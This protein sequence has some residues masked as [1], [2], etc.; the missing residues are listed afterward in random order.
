MISKKI[1]QELKNIDPTVHEYYLAK[2]VVER[3][4]RN[5]EKSNDILN[6]K[7]YV[8]MPGNFYSVGTFGGWNEY[9]F[10]L[11]IE[12]IEPYSHIPGSH[13]VN[14]GIESVYEKKQKSMTRLHVGIE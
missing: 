11:K 3:F 10:M 1:Q 13:Y 6:K 9:G 12:D 8:Q 2:Q 5:L 4:E 14:T 7:F